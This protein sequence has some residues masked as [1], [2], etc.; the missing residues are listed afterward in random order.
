MSRGFDS[1]RFHLVPSRE[2]DRWFAS[3]RSTVA[4]HRQADPASWSAVPRSSRESAARGGHAVRLHGRRLRRH[5]HAQ[6]GGRL[7]PRRPAEAGPDLESHRPPTDLAAGNSNGDFP[8]L[9]FTQYAD[10]PVSPAARSSRRRGARVRLHVGCREGAA[11]GRGRELDSGQ[12]QER[13]EASSSPTS[14]S[15]ERSPVRDDKPR[16][17]RVRGRHGIRHR[18][19]AAPLDAKDFPGVPPAKLVAGSLLLAMTPEAAFSPA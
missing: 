13:L 15:D 17:H 5:D 3:L 11:T 19:G 18:R 1:R 16:A 2:R 6:A 9:D 10:K 14:P 4:C 7:A 12:R 8:T